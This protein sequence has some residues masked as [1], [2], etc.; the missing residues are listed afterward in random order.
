MSE[1]SPF[2]LGH[3]HIAAVN[4][5]VRRHG[6]TLKYLN[7]WLFGRP[8]HYSSGGPVLDGSLDAMIGEEVI[9]LVGGSAH[10]VL[11]LAQ[12]RAAFDFVLPGAPELPVMRDAEVL[13]AAAVAAALR[14][15]IED[16]V[17]DLVCLLARSG[18][19][20]THVEPPPPIGDDPRLAR[21]LDLM[22]FVSEPERGPSPPSLR[23]KLW[24]LH[25][26]LVRTTYEASGVTYLSC[27]P[28]SQ[29]RSGFLRPEYY[30]Y[31]CHV[32]EDYGSLVLRQ[33]ALIP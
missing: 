22:G 4:Q 28:D 31:P 1:R 21:E 14:A 24:R 29:D 15:Q 5:A 12:H 23:L 16:E 30:A 3:S 27:P 7:L 8:V 11:G 10:D 13:P 9:S 18:R 33:L 19:K 25:S 17:L 6:L 20:V 32:N 26:E 2:I